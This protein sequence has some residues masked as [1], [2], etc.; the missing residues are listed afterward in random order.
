MTL[1]RRKV[2]GNESHTYNNKGYSLSLFVLGYCVILVRGRKS[3][4][5]EVTN[6]GIPVRDSKTIALILYRIDQALII[7]I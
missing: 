5:K 6:R 3:V 2:G 1:Y 7:V 4:L